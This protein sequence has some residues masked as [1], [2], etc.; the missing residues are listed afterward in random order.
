[1]LRYDPKKRISWCLL[2]QHKYFKIDNNQFLGE[3]DII[4]SDNLEIYKD[5]SEQLVPA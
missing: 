2:A 1:M 3:D 4:L 5:K